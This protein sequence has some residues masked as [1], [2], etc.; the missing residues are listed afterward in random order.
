MYIL[1]FFVQFYT[2]QPQYW[3]KK[4]KK[5]KMAQQTGQ[6]EL[7][8]SRL[9]PSSSAMRKP[10][11]WRRRRMKLFN[12]NKWMDATIL[13]RFQ[14]HFNNAVFFFFLFGGIFRQTSISHKAFSPKKENQT[15]LS[16]TANFTKI[17]AYKNLNEQMSEYKSNQ[18]KKKLW[19]T[20]SECM[21]CDTW[22]ANKNESASQRI[23]RRRHQH[24]CWKNHEHWAYCPSHIRGL[25][26]HTHT[27]R[28][29]YFPPVN[30]LIARYQVKPIEQSNH[31]TIESAFFGITFLLILYNF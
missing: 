4:Q 31:R 19:E 12:I 2:D 25:R 5:K 10:N 26:A 9:H 21:A 1:D 7:V 11:L 16:R 3:M 6:F 23:C 13:H 8:A 22:N 28:L 20:L 27:H 24:R 18:E 17:K 29:R 30:Y 14:M 15:I